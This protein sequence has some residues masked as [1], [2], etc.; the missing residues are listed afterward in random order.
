MKR[1]NLVF[2]IAFVV[3]NYS[4]RAA[5]FSAWSSFIS[6]IHRSDLNQH[7]DN[8]HEQQ[9]YNRLLKLF[10]TPFLPDYTSKSK[11]A[12]LAKC[13]AWL[14][15]VLIYPT[16]VNDVLIPFLSFAFGYHISSISTVTSWWS[17]CCQLGVE[18][19]HKLLT[20]YHTKNSEY[21]IK[22]AGNQIL[23]YIF[24]SIYDEILENSNINENKSSIGFICWNS[25]ITHLTNIYT[26]N[27]S[28][29]DEQRHEIG[30]TYKN[31]G[32]DKA[33]ELGL[34]LI[35]GSIKEQRIRDW[36]HFKDNNNNFYAYRSVFCFFYQQ[37]IILFKFH[38]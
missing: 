25:F 7:N 21:I 33:I 8:I 27:N 2:L 6:H 4:I 32:Q 31:E 16:H 12:S 26:M 23:N 38:S 35:S 24:D 20:S 10:L 28:I 18:C 30:L 14:I 17:E 19:L 15:L 1:S 11:S 29:D 13:R 22:I 5:A 37:H 9:L 34:K 3:A 36:S